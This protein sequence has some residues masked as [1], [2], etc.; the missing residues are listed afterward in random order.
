[1]ERPVGI[2][3]TWSA[4]KAEARPLGEGCL[5]VVVVVVVVVAPGA[6]HPD[7]L[8]GLPPACGFCSHSGHSLECVPGKGE[9][10]QKPSLMR[11]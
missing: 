5:V 8:S 1:M 2:E 3:P 7:S 10:L 6:F 11:A 4:W 9:H